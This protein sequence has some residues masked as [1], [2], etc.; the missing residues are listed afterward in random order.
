MDGG[1]RVSLGLRLPKC[2][3]YSLKRVSVRCGLGS[4]P[5]VAIFGYF[6][7]SVMNSSG[8]T[9]SVMG[10]AREILFRPPD[11]AA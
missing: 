2:S 7:L 8:G 5:A 4:N 10:M 11:F 3:N 1:L 6:G 9:S